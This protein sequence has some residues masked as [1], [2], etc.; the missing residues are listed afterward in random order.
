MG[1]GASK[2]GGAMRNAGHSTSIGPLVKH[3][4]LA[5]SQSRITRR[6]GSSLRAW[7]AGTCSLS[8]S[9]QA[10]MHSTKPCKVWPWLT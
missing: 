8:N 7:V 1:T 10:S 9:P 4:Q 5:N 2:C 6:L 3:G